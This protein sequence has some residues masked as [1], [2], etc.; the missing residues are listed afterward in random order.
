[1]VTVIRPG[2]EIRK[3]IRTRLRDWLLRLRCRYLHGMK[4]G[5]GIGLGNH[6]RWWSRSDYRCLKCGREY[7]SEEM[8]YRRNANSPWVERKVMWLHCRWPK[9]QMQS[10]TGV[11]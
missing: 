1:M 3:R 11:T 2:Q 9:T 5:H 8:G 6:F 7:H 4:S 10:K